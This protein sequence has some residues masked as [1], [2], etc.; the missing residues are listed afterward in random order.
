MV[1]CIEVPQTSHCTTAEVAQCSMLPPRGSQELPHVHSLRG[2]ESAAG[3]PG[4]T[5]PVTHTC[6][7][8]GSQGT[9]G[10][11]QVGFYC[12][13]QGSQGRA[14]S[15]GVGWEGR[16][17]VCRTERVRAVT[18]QDA[19]KEGS[20]TCSGVAQ[21]HTDTHA[22]ITQWPNKTKMTNRI[23]YMMETGMQLCL[24]QKNRVIVFFCQW[25]SS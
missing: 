13:L 24:G 21:T 23:M 22:H 17:Q 25:N 4:Y 11:G 9:T 5:A 7:S 19:C 16:I 3:K 20:E 8:Q 2:R 1:S 12:P 10:E 15:R 6:R 14:C 18:A